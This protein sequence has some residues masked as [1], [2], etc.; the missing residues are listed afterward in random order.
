MNDKWKI[1]PERV[2]GLDAKIQR[3]IAAAI[4]R[5]RQIALLPYTKIE[6]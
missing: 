3:K 2:T 6:R 4:K 1:S 5:S